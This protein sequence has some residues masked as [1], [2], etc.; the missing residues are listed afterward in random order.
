M[1]QYPQLAS[2]VPAHFKIPPIPLF[3]NPSLL[4]YTTL[5]EKWKI[6]VA[7]HAGAA[8]RLFGKR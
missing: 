7:I 8:A 4:D 6:A 3:K 2:S 5:L 1:H